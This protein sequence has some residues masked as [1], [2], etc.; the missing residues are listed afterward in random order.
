[1]RGMKSKDRARIVRDDRKHLWHPFTW[2]PG[3]LAEKPLV[4]TGAK[5]IF[6]TAAACHG[7][8][9]M[10]SGWRRDGRRYMDGISSMWLNVHGHNRP[11]IIRAIHAQ[12]KK[13]A[14]V[15]VFGQTHAPAVELARRLVEIAPGNETAGQSPAAHHNNTAWRGSD[16]PR[17]N[18]VFFS[19]D[20]AT[21]VEVA[22]KLAFQFAQIRGE[23][24]RTKFLALRHAYHGDT[25]GAVAVG[26]IEHFHHAFKPLLAPCLRT[27]SPASMGRDACLA[28]LERILKRHSRE[29][30]AFIV[31]PVVQGAAGMLVAAEGY[32]AGARALCTKYHVPLIADEVF[33]GFGRT[34]RMFACEHERVTPDIL[35]VA[36]GLTGGTLPLAATLATDRIYRA[37][38]GPDRVGCTFFHGHSYT[39][40]PLGCAAAL[41]S[42]DLFEQDDTLANVRA[43]ERVIAGE[44]PRFA[45]LSGVSGVRFVGAIFALDLPRGVARAVCAEAQCRG[46]LIR[47]LGDTVYLVPPLVTTAKQLRGMLDIVH[48][49]IRKVTR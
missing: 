5:G 6:L 33:T 27:P 26:D 41:A 11:E 4:I 28:A 34:G 36:K 42:L 20:G 35:C 39:A 30:C 16:P 40:N 29:I 45:A 23:R 38:L 21:S 17:L 2:M 19:D 8:V 44:S 32:L 24:K 22:L 7:E 9:P 15:S 12:A 14:H 18:H 37:F 46:L 25:L 43:L 3:Y 13:F 31:E 47:P 49:S 1:M 48:G 10:K